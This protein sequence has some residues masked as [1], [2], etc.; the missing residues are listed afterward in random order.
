[1]LPVRA[2]RC[3]LCHLMP[4]FNMISMSYKSYKESSETV[5]PTQ[6]AKIYNGTME[7]K[8]EKSANFNKWK[9]PGNDKTRIPLTGKLCTSTAFVCSVLW[10]WWMHA[11]RNIKCTLQ[12]I[13]WKLW[14]RSHLDFPHSLSSLLS[15]LLCFFSPFKTWHVILTIQSAVGDWQVSPAS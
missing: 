11:H 3:H 14:K 1:M 6:R 7:A 9:T 2:Q 13:F 8:T 10:L 4:S 5:C 15:P 12:G